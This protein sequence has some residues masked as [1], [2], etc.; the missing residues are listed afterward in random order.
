M[1]SSAPVAAKLKQHLSVLYGDATTEVSAQIEQLIANYQ[2][3][4]SAHRSESRSLWDESTVV[5]ITYGD[6]IRDEG[7]PAL[8][9]LRNFLVHHQLD[10]SISCRN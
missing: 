5:L 9:S 3:D 10:Q 8:R 7:I 6:Q 4:I 1:S 2:P